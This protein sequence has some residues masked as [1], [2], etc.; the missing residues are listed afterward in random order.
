MAQKTT[1]ESRRGAPPPTEEA[2]HRFRVFDAHLHAYRPEEGVDVWASFGAFRD[3]PKTYVR[4]SP[5]LLRKTIQWMD[6]AGVRQ[7]L[8]SHYNDSV[9]EWTQ[10]YPDRF[11]PSYFPSPTV[12]DSLWNLDRFRKDARKGIWR[13]LGEVNLPWFV[14]PINDPALFPYY[15]VC[16][17]LGL[18]VMM[19]TGPD[20][21]NNY[22]YD[23]TLGDPL[24]LRPVLRMF[25]KLRFVLYHMGWPF[26]D[27]ALYMSYAFENVYLEV[28]AVIWL[29]PKVTLRM[30]RETV[31]A[32]G[33][34]RLLFG[35]DQMLWPQMILKAVHAIAE[36]ENLSDRDK[37]RILWDNASTLFNLAGG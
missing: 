6:R 19:H 27:R 14:R 16:E 22:D 34:D 11:L 2:T 35:T 18:P 32:I 31:D 23:V 1:R 28:G 5:L 13:A 8:L 20:A 15:G 33:S 4:T 10:K 21:V 17:K 9:L 7:G 12:G 24:L 30:V 29:F 3:W 26:F 36:E 25:P 37:R